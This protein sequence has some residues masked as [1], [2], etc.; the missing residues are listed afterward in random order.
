MF[1]KDIL[2]LKEKDLHRIIRDRESPQGNRIWING[3]ELINFSSNDY[4]GLL[5][6]PDILKAATEAIKLYGSGAGASRLLSGSCIIHRRLEEEMARFKDTEDCIIFNSGYAANTGAIPALTGSDDLILSD[7]L[8]HASIIDGCR[9]S[10]AKTIVY[11]HRDTEQIKGIISREGS[12]VRGRIMIVTDSVFSMDG[13]IAPIKELFNICSELNSEE[14]NVRALLYIDDAHGTGVIGNAK[15][16]IAH[17]GLESREWLI[18]MGTFSK[19]LGSFGAFVAGTSDL[20]DWL[21]NR[22]RSFIFSTALPVPVIASALKALEIIMTDDEPLKRLWTNRERL[23]KGLKEMGFD[24][25]GSETPIIPIIIH[26]VEKVLFMSR[27]LE[28]RGIYVPAIRPPTVKEPRLRL[29]VT[30]SHTEEEIDQ[31]IGALR[32]VCGDK[33]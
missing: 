8:N 9:L 27:S 21:R 18:Q 14:D 7:E 2:L 5:N 30:A 3:K 12:R 15:G 10:K 11:R 16:A 26:N 29:S 17:Y 1:E 20:I 31:L 22:A 25:K 24:I 4:L 6:H 28:E 23:V 32:D 13:D 33:N 19:A